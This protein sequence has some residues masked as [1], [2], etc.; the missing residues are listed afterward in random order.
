MARQPGQ[1]PETGTG[2][3][4]TMIGRRRFLEVLAA[5]GVSQTLPSCATD[6][7]VS[8]DSY[9]FT[10]GVASG[11][12][13]PGSV[14]L[15]TRLTG[16]LDPVALPVRWE[17][18]ADEAM[19]SVISSGVASAEPAWAH[20]VHVEVAGLAPDRWYWYRFTT[21]DAQSPV[22]RTRTA[23]APGSDPQRL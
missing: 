8:F 9:P 21:A 22:G 20:S 2:Y 13:S 14:V 3:A 23:P 16:D 19:K 18:A 10:L 7:K 5:L 4:L 6:R 15:W 12:P 11:Y 1:H 17:I